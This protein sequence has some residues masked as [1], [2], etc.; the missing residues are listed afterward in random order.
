MKLNQQD[1]Y[2]FSIFFLLIIF[3]LPAQDRLSGKLFATRSEVIAKNGMAATTHPLATQIAIDILK[4]GGSAVDAAIAAN[5]FLGFADPAM[6]GLGGDL[7]AIVWS[8]KEQKLYGLNAS[9]KSPKA[10]N[11]SY[12]S[13]R[14][15]NKMPVSGPLSI[16]VPGAVDGWFELHD[17]FGKLKFNKLLAPTI[18]Y[19]REGIAVTEEIA[20]MMD[21]LDRDLIRSYGLDPSFQWEDLPNFNHLYRKNGRFPSKGELYKNSDLANTLEIIGNKGRSAFY[22]G[23]IAETIVDHVQKLGGF[24]S[25]EDFSE[26]SSLWV[27]PISV[28]YRGFDVWE[29]PPNG[30]GISVLQMLNILEGYAVSDF[31]FG[32]K[33]HIHYFSEAKKIVFADL[34]EYYGDP[35]FNQLPLKQL[36]SKDYA[37]KRREEIKDNFSQN[38][39]PGLEPESNTTYL[40]VADKEGNMVSLIQSNSWLFGSLIVPPGLGFVLQNRGSGFNLQEGHANAYAPEKR[41]LS[42]IIPA[43]ITKDGNPY[44]SFG[45]TGSDMQPQ[46]HVQII[47]NL[48]DFKMN[49]QEAGDAPRIRHSYFGEPSPRNTGAIELESGFS[50]ETIRDLMKMGHRVKFG[51]ER[52]GGFQGILF[53]GNFYYGASESRKDGQAAGY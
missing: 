39:G 19:A 20:E 9:G 37:S 52:F 51:F 10:L 31:G 29:M 18:Q 13:L 22:S 42:T 33:E 34:N 26:H 40:T 48:I 45:L 38:Y 30:Q 44:V 8:A 23:D 16:T 15:M 5:V 21:Y 24:L 2:L 25:E 14:G 4:Q 17:K 47:M 28:N 43:F 27:E 11:F 41:P 6:N 36:L 46:G 1:I 50:Y 7:F 3:N 35:T 32:S 12:F 49:L 53:D